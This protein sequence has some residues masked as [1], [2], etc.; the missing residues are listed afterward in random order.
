MATTFTKI[1]SV[2]VGVLG[3]A[4]IEFTSIPST[5]TDLCLKISGR[6]THTSLDQTE[7]TFNG[8]ATGY[9]YRSIFGDG[10]SAASYGAGGSAI[11][12]YIPLQY[13]PGIAQTSNTFT[14]SEMYIPNYAGS[15]NKSVSFDTVEENNATAAYAL[16]YAAIWSNTAA[17][18]SIKIDPQNGNFAQYSTATLYGIKNS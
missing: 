6:S 15:N 5:Y 9:N 13:L 10:S 12:T 8:S 4:N 11:T 17:I 7:I 14:S 1:A 3:A 16:I 18:A 2:S